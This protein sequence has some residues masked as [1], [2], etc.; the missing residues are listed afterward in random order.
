MSAVQGNS[1][2]NRSR[3]YAG[4]P[5]PLADLTQP[6]LPGFEGIWKSPTRCSRLPGKPKP[7][8]RGGPVH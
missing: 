2:N 4:Q 6:V 7:G 5:P 8:G 1:P 3:G